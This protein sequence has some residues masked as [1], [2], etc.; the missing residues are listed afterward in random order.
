[1]PCSSGAGR[2]GD[3]SCV[4]DTDP[5]RSNF[6]AARATGIHHDSNVLRAGKSDQHRR[7]ADHTP[8]FARFCP[9]IR[10]GV[11]A[12][13][14]RKSQGRYRMNLEL[15][16]S[17]GALIKG[18][19]VVL[20]ALLVLIPVQLLQGLVQERAQLRQ[21]AV[22]TVARGWGGTQLLGGPVLAIPATVTRDDGRLSIIDWYVLPET[23]T[24]ESELVV[25]DERRK[26][27][28]YEV[29]V[30]V[31]SVRAVATF[32]IASKVASLMQGPRASTLHLDRARLIVPVSDTR[33]VRD[34][35]IT[36]TSVAGGVFEPDR[37][38]EMGALATP[39]R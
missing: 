21:E 19:M 26:L 24:L 17:Q 4:D 27:G 9:P 3:S 13:C 18:I 35:R 12:P 25:Q 6:R 1:M 20:V 14:A 38:F 11:P 34:V 2:T 39:L 29:P 28:V 15:G 36:G 22:N 31:T 16:R 7:D 30:Y 33:G 37:S 10:H 5:G 32:D 8:L 23:L